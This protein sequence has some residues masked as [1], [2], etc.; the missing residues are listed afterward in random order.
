MLFLASSTSVLL[1]FLP[2]DV[3]AKTWL[4]LP[5]FWTLV[6]AVWCHDPLVPSRSQVLDCWKWR[7]RALESLR[8]RAQGHKDSKRVVPKIKYTQ[9]GFGHHSFQ[10]HTAKKFKVILGYTASLRPGRGYVS[11]THP[12]TPQK[13]E[14]E[15]ERKK[16][17]FT[18]RTGWKK[19]KIF[20]KQL[21]CCF[22]YTMKKI[23]VRT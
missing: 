21:K 12:Q 3:L 15:G 14:K 2:S 23:S 11:H 8:W 16:L 7:N 6:S 13:K 1:T 22:A 5:P 10:R 18:Q 19:Y 9:F 4:I 20:Q 17:K